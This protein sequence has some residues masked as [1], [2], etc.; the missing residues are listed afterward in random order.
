MK[1]SYKGKR[2][3]KI[4]YIAHIIGMCSVCALAVSI[5]SLITNSEK[6]DFTIKG[7]SCPAKHDNFSIAEAVR[8]SYKQNEKSLVLKKKSQLSETLY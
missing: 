4:I 8:L 5:D 3:K 7:K 1:N 6:I 2:V